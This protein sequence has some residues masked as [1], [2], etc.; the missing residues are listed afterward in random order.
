MIG[1]SAADILAGKAAGTTTCD[2]L[3]GSGT[4]LEIKWSGLNLVTRSIQ[5]FPQA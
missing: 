3:Y 1:D 5:K 2:A 4:Q